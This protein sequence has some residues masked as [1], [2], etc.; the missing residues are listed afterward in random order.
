MAKLQLA[1]HKYVLF[2][3]TYSVVKIDFFSCISDFVFLNVTQFIAV[4]ELTLF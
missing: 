1:D 2:V 4:L 3:L